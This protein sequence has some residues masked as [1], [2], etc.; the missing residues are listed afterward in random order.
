MAGLRA[1]WQGF[2][3]CMCHPG[4]GL[5]ALLA[6]PH[7]SHR[8][9]FFH[10]ISTWERVVAGFPPPGPSIDPG[11]IGD[12]RALQSVSEERSARP[13]KGQIAAAERPFCR[14]C[15]GG[16]RL[17]R[18]ATARLLQQV[19]EVTAGRH[20]P[21]RH[22][23]SPGAGRSRTDTDGQRMPLASG[24]RK[25]LATPAAPLVIKITGSG[26]ISRAQGATRDPVRW[27]DG[28]PMR[29]SVAVTGA[30]R[31]STTSSSHAGQARLALSDTCAPPPH[32]TETTTRRSVKA[33]EGY[34][35]FAFLP[36][37]QEWR[38]PGF[39]PYASSE[40]RLAEQPPAAA[41]CGAGT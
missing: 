26:R 14:C 31:G 34:E 17:R 27:S 23:G 11:E 33:L 24:G 1:R 5:R 4:D 19:I 16:R 28:P 9:R 35:A 8:H 39:R 10:A 38:T 37:V 25:P 6:A 40:R 12:S 32:S 22:G 18:I 15:R 41:P 20:A 2:A 21:V 30:H 13:T 29:T 7:A 36:D 3:T